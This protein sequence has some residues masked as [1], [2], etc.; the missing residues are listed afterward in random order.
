MPKKTLVFRPGHIT[1]TVGDP[2]ASEGLTEDEVPRLM[3][4]TRA[5]VGKH[6]DTNYNPFQKEGRRDPLDKGRR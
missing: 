2:I 5:A 3:E 6:L 4:K 1:V